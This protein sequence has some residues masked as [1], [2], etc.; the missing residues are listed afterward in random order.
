[1]PPIDHRL[2]RDKRDELDLS[3]GD[4][5]EILGTKSTYVVNIMCGSRSPS[6]RLIHR[7]SRALDLPVDKIVV[8]QD[9]ERTPQGD[10]SGPPVQPKNE[11]VGP[12]RRQ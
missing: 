5:A 8:S 2:V 12:P 9:G 10:P 7:L 11:P 4:L 1:M 3:N 6:R